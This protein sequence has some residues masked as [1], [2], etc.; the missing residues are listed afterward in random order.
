MS[1]IDESCVAADMRRLTDRQAVMEVC[2]QM[3]WHTDER[4]WD[5]LKTVFADEV[6]LDYTSLNG[7]EPATL[8]PEQIVE[9]WSRVLGGFASTQHL[10]GNPVASVMGDTA[11][12]TAP[13]Q[14]T[15]R[16]ATEY[17]DSLWTLGGTYRFD[18]RRAGDNWRITGVVMCARW[19]DGNEKLMERAS[20]RQARN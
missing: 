18:L 5:M 6:R 8:S 9:G 19:G 17:G 3:A 16:L 14:A 2:T 4:E 1:V 7:G 15:H 13:F 11:V 10:L 12:C 20:S